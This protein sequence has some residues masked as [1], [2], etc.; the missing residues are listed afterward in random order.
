MSSRGEIKEHSICQS[1]YFLGP[2]LITHYPFLS[3]DLV[4]VKVKLPSTLLFLC[5]G[6]R[7]YPNS[8]IG[9][10]LAT[11]LLTPSLQPQYKR[12]VLLTLLFIE[13]KN[14]RGKKNGQR[15]SHYCLFDS[16]KKK[17]PKKPLKYTNKIIPKQLIFF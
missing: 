11:S 7:W 15:I 17:K 9:L 1:V 10:L 16:L 4:C 13:E 3:A 5:P 8:T 2:P 14:N 12:Q 6:R